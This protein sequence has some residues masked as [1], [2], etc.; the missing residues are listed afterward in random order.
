VKRSQL[1][2]TLC[3]LVRHPSTGNEV[4]RLEREIDIYLSTKKQAEKQS[5]LEY[6]CAAVNT[7]VEKHPSQ[8]LFWDTV[9]AYIGRAKL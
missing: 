7:E 9:K 6:L 5:A 1:M 8:R 4:P 2:T 3:M